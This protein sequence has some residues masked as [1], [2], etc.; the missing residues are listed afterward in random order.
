MMV[1]A[2]AICVDIHIDVDDESVGVAWFALVCAGMMITTAL[3]MAICVDL[4]T[5]YAGDNVG[6]GC[7]RYVCI[8]CDGDSVG[9]GRVR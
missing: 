1:L 5:S 8:G 4:R 3:A 2:M 7:L 9:A 6:V